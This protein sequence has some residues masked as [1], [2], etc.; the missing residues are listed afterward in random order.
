MPVSRPDSFVP[1]TPTTVSSAT[2]KIAP[3]S[4]IASS[5]ASQVGRPKSVCRYALQ[6]R[7]TTAAPRPSS[8]T[9]SQP[10]IQATNSPSVA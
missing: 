8:S 7:A 10:M 6:P 5:P 9:R 3:Q 2:M 1:T 4:G